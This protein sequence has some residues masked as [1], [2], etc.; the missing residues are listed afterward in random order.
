MRAAA[1]KI[2][3]QRG[4]DLRIARVSLALEQGHGRND[5]AVDAVSALDRLLV[6]KRLL[7]RMEPRLVADPFDSDDLVTGYRPQRRVARRHGI[8]VQQH[9]ARA[10][11]RLAAAEPRPLQLQIVTKDVQQ[12]GA[13][14][15]LNFAVATIDSKLERFSHRLFEWRRS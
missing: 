4:S 7:Q 3:I 14:L 12:R 5:D 10:A 13:R 1:A 2:S 8:A 11:L 15:G 9:V 6:D